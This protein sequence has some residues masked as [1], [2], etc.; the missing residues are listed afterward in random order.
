LIALLNAAHASARG[1]TLLK[2]NCIVHSTFGGML[3]SDM[4]CPRCNGFSET[5]DPCLDISLGL[6]L[7]PG[8]STLA[9]CLKR[10]AWL[11]PFI[12]SN[13]GHFC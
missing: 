4:R 7:S 5:I 6:G 2:C 8:Q 13:L 12:M 11:W 9:G 3:Q 10:C 1:S